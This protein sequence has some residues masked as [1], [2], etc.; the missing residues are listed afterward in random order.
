MK[1]AAPGGCRLVAVWQDSFAGEASGVWEPQKEEAGS[2]RA[3]A[4][5][6]EETT[7]AEEAEDMTWTGWERLA[8]GEEG[9]TASGGQGERLEAAHIAAVAAVAA[10]VAVAAAEVLLIER[11][12]MSNVEY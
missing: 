1:P 7:Y 2:L 8:S 11:E 5:E 10:A 4:G 3:S 9:R 6:G 12:Y